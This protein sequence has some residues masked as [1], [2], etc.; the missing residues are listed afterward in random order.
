MGSVPGRVSFSFLVPVLRVRGGCNPS[1]T[2]AVFVPKASMDEDDFPS[3]DED[4]I[5]FARKAAYMKRISIAH[6]VDYPPYA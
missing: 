6:R 5:G 4:D 1:V 3:L 2:T